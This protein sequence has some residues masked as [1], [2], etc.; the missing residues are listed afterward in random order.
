LGDRFHREQERLQKLNYDVND[1]AA[2][3]EE[4]EIPDDRNY[5]VAI[6]GQAKAIKELRRISWE[7]SGMAGKLQEYFYDITD[8]QDSVGAIQ[9]ES[10]S[11]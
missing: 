7:L 11:Q 3:C 5:R 2:L 6:E 4:I 1:L 9:P 8:I 10:S